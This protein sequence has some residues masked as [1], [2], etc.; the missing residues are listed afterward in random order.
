MVTTGKWKWLSP[1]RPHGLYS[2]W[3]SPGWNT[4]VPSC[5]L[6]Q[7]I[8]PNQGSKPG[9][10]HCR[11]TLYQLSHQGSSGIQEWVVYPFSSGSSWTRSWTRSPA[12]QMNSLPAEQLDACNLKKKQNTKNLCTL[13]SKLKWIVYATV[14]L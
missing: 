9:L 7:R 10:P 4:G 14:K 1:V 11:Q 13:Y 6:L 2:P 5:S 12:L 8:F 3:N